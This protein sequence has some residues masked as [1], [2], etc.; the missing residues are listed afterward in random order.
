MWDLLLIPVC[1]HKNVLFCKKYSKQI[2]FFSK[3]RRRKSKAAIFI[4]PYD[5]L[6]FLEHFLAP[7]FGWTVCIIYNGCINCYVRWWRQNADTDIKGYAW[8]QSVRARNKIWT[9]IKHYTHLIFLVLFCRYPYKTI[10]FNSA[11]F[12]RYGQFHYTV[13][14]SFFFFSTTA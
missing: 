10:F 8:N 6:T 5:G 4:P 3:C 14:D 7:D 2:Y 1:S 12:Q 13:S 9:E 11:I